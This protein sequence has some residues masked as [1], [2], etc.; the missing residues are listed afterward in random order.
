MEN[1]FGANRNGENNEPKIKRK[2]E[3]IRKL[4]IKVI[5]K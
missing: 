2:M 4:K 3:T 1:I 5:S